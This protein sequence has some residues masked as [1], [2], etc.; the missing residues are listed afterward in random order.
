MR[1]RSDFLAEGTLVITRTPDP[2]LGGFA[3]RVP[4]R[5]KLV[6]V[7]NAR[8]MV[9]FGLSPLS[10][11]DYIPCALHGHGLP[12]LTCAHLRDATSPREAV[13]LYGLDGDYPDLLCPACVD[14]LSG[15]DAS[16]CLTICSRCLQPDMY[17]HHILTTTWYGA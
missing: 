10:A 8:C 11:C 14:V 15:G 7:L 3:A 4:L 2:I 5:R 13:V 6:E 9:D 1:T 12:A 17:R 16:G